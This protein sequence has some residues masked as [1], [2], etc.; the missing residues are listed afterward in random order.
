MKFT[1][2][3]KSNDNAKLGGI[4]SGLAYYYNID[5][6]WLRI[7]FAFLFVFFGLGGLLL[8]SYFL[9]WVVIDDYDAKYAFEDDVIIEGE[10]V[11]TDNK[12]ENPTSNDSESTI[13]DITKEEKDK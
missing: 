5:S 2:I 3:M 13:D 4:L 7:I 8:L 6:F 1:K 9:A 10:V 12:E 11:V